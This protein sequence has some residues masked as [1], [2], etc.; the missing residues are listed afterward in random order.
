MEDAI[1]SDDFQ[2]E[3]EETGNG[4]FTPGFCKSIFDSCFKRTFNVEY[5]FN[6][7]MK[8]FKQ[9]YKY[10][11]EADKPIIFILWNDRFMS[12]FADQFN[13]VLRDF[14]DSFDIYYCNDREEAKQYFN[15]EVMPEVFPH[16][17]I[18]DPNVKVPITTKD[19]TKTDNHYYTKHQSFIF[20]F[21]SPN[22]ELMKTIDNFLDDKLRNHFVT[23]DRTQKTFV[24][25][26][27]SENFKSEVLENTG[28][29]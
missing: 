23:E 4:L 27:N 25:W 28:V 11:K 6:T 9:K 24:K 26:I 29:K 2:N 5:M 22:E 18:I 21:S 13:I 8:E 10:G 1:Y 3:L 19:G 14:T 7:D 16:I 20:N 15:T 17:Y 12:H